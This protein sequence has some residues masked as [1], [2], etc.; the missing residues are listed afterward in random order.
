M[1]E[2]EADVNAK[3]EVQFAY[4]CNYGVKTVKCEKVTSEVPQNFC[5]AACP[6]RYGSLAEGYSVGE[7]G[8]NLVE[9]GTLALKATQK[10]FTC[11]YGVKIKKL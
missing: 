3:R 11:N 10:K 1:L 9:A 8:R 4:S 7:C 5:I 2:V 6:D